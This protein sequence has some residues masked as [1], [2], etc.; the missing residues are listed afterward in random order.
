MRTIRLKDK[1]HRR[2]QILTRF[3]PARLTESGGCQPLGIRTRHPRRLARGCQARGIACRV[4]GNTARTPRHATSQATRGQIPAPVG[5][6]GPLRDPNVRHRQEIPARHDIPIGRST[7]ERLLKEKGLRTCGRKPGT[8]RPRREREA[9]EG[10]LLRIDGSA[11][12]WRG[13]R[14]TMTLIGA[15]DDATGKVLS[16]CSHPGQGQQAYPRM[17]RAI[18]LE[19]GPPRSVHHDRHTILRPPEGATLDDEPAGGSR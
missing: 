15:M 9:S 7:P 1:R 6:S 12:D 13:A 5:H 18:T 3:A 14:P 19:H 17:L 2:A 4:H 16:L 11:H 8:K 10:M